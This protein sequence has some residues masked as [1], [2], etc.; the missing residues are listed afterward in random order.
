MAEGVAD[1]TAERIRC[2]RICLDEAI[3]NKEI[4][5]VEECCHRLVE[6]LPKQVTDEPPR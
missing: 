1:T 5:L 3:T 2:C 4:V 6:L